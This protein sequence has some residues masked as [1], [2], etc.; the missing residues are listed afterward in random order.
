[1]RRKKVARQ[2][3]DDIRAS[4]HEAIDLAAGR[5]TK[6]VVRC[7]SSRANRKAAL[8]HVIKTEPKAVRRAMVKASS[9]T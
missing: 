9:E 5:R 7:A 4:L 3:A 1:L 6:A 2:L 8:I